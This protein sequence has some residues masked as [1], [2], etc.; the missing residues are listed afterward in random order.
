M[1]RW[2][3]ITVVLLVIA[4]TG[5]GCTGQQP[6]REDAEWITLLDG[7]SGLENWNRVGDANWRAE[8][9]SSMLTGRPTRRAASS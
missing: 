5:F 4:F 1:N 6:G 8:M 7:A 3:S 2:S 9:A